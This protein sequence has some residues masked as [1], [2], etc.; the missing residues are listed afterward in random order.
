METNNQLHI[1]LLRLLIMMEHMMDGYH[2][3]TNQHTLILM[4]L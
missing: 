3:K 2:Q 4:E 1:C